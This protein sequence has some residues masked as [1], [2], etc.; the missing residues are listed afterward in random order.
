M[1]PTYPMY[2]H[3]TTQSTGSREYFIFLL[4]TESLK[5]SV[6]FI[7]TAHL[8]LDTT[9]SLETPDPGDSFTYPSSPKHTEK[10]PVN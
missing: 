8:N 9:F 2:Y 7:L 5:S 1:T 6:S 3:F 4:H 10:R